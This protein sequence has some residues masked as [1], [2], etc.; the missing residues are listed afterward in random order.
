MSGFAFRSV[1][2]SK[3]D[4][5]TF[6]V[7]SRGIRRRREVTITYRK[8]T[9]TKPETRCVQPHLL[10]N[11]QN[12]WYAVCFDPQKNDFRRFALPRIKSTHLGNTKFE[13]QPEFSA[14]KFLANAFGAF[15]GSEDIEVRIRFDAFA[16]TFV[17]ER[18][19]HPTEKFKT[20][21]KG[22]LEFSMHVP[23]LEE[24]ESWALGWGAHAKVLAPPQL[25]AMLRNAGKAIAAQYK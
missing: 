16:A 24:V 13:R 22:G 15:G 7:I 21:P 19:W 25:V 20:L 17:Q 18:F 12:L 6:D 11:I 9:S 8:P 4:L 3:A 14:D 1:G 23:R 2:T 10:A 5:V